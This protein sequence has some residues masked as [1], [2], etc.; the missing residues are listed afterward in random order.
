MPRSRSLPP[1]RHAFRT[2]PTNSARSS[3]L[4]MADPPP[5][6]G[7]TGATTE[8]TTKPFARI[9]SASRF[10]SSSLASMLMGIEEEQIHALEFDAAHF[11]RGSQVQ[12]RVQVDMGL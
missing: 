12:H 10:N 8:P 6:G 4:P 7:Q 5:V 2:C 11:R 9:L 1:M 3:L